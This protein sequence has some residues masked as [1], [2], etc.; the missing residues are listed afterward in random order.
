MQFPLSTVS[1]YFA[2]LSEFETL[3]G[4]KAKI[5]RILAPIGA[6]GK[7]IGVFGNFGV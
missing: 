3:K 2:T 5:K 4:L 7:I 6:T 1:F